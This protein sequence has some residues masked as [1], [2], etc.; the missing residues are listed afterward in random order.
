MHSGK[1]E[2]HCTQLCNQEASFAFKKPLFLLHLETVKEKIIHSSD[3][4][5][6]YFTTMS[7]L[8]Q[9]VL[10]ALNELTTPKGLLVLGAL[11]VLSHRLYFIR[12]EH[13]LQAP[14][15]AQVYVLSS[16]ALLSTIFLGDT[17]ELQYNQSKAALDAIRILGLLNLSYFVPL[18]TSVVIYRLFEHRLKDF[19]GPRMAAAT[20]LW[21]F[22][23]ILFTSNNRLLDQLHYKYGRII[24]TGM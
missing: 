17:L 24:R 8:L 3:R 22:W 5:S 21:H 18:F 23:N 13:H 20:K 10:S 11:G 19:D 14:M 15:Y 12:G 6:P 7:R 1:V 16:V 4:E 2:K 9:P